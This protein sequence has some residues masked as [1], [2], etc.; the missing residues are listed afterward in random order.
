MHAQYQEQVRYPATLV[1]GE[2][3]KLKQ[4]VDKTAQHGH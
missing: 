3:L 4:Q 2:Y 1:I